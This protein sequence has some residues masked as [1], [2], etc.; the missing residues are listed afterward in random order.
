MWY[1]KVEIRINSI[2]C[3]LDIAELHIKYDIG[4]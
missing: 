4:K 1:L 2:N 3:N